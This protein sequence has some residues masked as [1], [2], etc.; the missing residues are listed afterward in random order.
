VYFVTTPAYMTFMDA[1]QAINLELLR[2]FQSERIAVARPA[3]TV[4]LVH[5]DGATSP[6]SVAAR[7]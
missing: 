7:P 1:Q 3:S 2:R 6:T 5:A 4:T